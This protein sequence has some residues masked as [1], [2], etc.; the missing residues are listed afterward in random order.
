METIGWAEAMRPHVA[1]TM[2]HNYVATKKVGGKVLGAAAGVGYT[3]HGVC[4]FVYESHLATLPEEPLALK[5]RPIRHQI[6]DSFLSADPSD[7]H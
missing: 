6:L 3:Q 1:G 5:V 7:A 4:S 2:L